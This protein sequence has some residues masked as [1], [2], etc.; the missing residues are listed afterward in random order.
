MKI[1]ANLI[2]VGNV[3][4]HKDRMMEVLNTST[5]KPGKGGAFIQV[6]MK[7]MKTGTKFNERWRTSD[8]VEKVS[9]NEIN[10]TF[11]YIENDSFT[12]MNNQ[13]YEQMTYSSKLISGKEK[14]LEDGMNIT[15]EMV[16]DKISTVK[17]PKNIKVEIKTADAVVKG[18]TASSSYKNALTTNELSILVPPHIKEGD[19]VMINSE[20]LNYIEKAKD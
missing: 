9:V 1:N 14:F 3:L 12:V 10:V 17:F 13:N 7:D 20:T 19:K 6:E 15:L 11:L 18:Q 4:N 5:I 8:S 16:D 2:R